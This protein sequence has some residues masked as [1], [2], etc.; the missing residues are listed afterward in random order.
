MRCTCG[1]FLDESSDQ[2]TEIFHLLLSCFE[3]RLCSSITRLYYYKSLENIPNSSLSFFSITV[4]GS[5]KIARK[6]AS[7]V[8]CS[9]YIHFIF[10]KCSCISIITQDV[11]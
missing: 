6:Y 11:L 7:F 2:G 9:R 10:E 3:L 4:G 5:H 1:D 8:S